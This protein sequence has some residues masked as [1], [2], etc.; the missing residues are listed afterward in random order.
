ML[1]PVA[2]AALVTGRAGR[3]GR[4]VRRRQRGRLPRG[5]HRGQGDVV[6]RGQRHG[7]EPDDGAH[8][9]RGGDGRRRGGDQ[10]AVTLELGRGEGGL[11]RALHG[12][13]GGLGLHGPGDPVHRGHGHAPGAQPRRDLVD[14]GL[15]GAE[16]AV[17]LGLRDDLALGDVL[18]GE[19]LVAHRQLQ[20]DVD[21]GGGGGPTG[22][23]RRRGTGRRDPGGDGGGHGD[24]A[25]TGPGRRH[26]EGGGHRCRDERG[27]GDRGHRETSSLHDSPLSRCCRTGHAGWPIVTEV[28]TRT[29]SPQGLVR[30]GCTVPKSLTCT[31]CGVPVGWPSRLCSDRRSRRSAAPR[32]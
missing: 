32:A 9:E 29:A 22:D 27:R 24:L 18:L 10:A 15:R 30:S 6:R 20:R 2:R 31:T 1:P 17:V 12:G 7:V 21:R 23:V 11:Q 8:A 13:D 14:L 3:G 16:G 19:P 4:E 28:V 26:R 25:V 5:S